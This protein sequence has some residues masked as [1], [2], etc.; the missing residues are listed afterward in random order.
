MGYFPSYARRTISGSTCPTRTTSSAV[1]ARPREK[2]KSEFAWACRPRATNTS[3]GSREPAEQAEPL[4]AQFPFKSSPARSPMLSAPRTT[5][6]SQRASQKIAEFCS[7]ATR[8][9][10]RVRGFLRIKRKAKAGPTKGGSEKL[11]NL[12]SFPRLPQK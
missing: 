5:N 6:P 4:E 10:V 1:E 2:R 9:K 11:K 8:K 3:E 12:V 7:G